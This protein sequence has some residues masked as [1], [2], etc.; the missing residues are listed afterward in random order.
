[1]AFKIESYDFSHTFVRRPLMVHCFACG[2]ICFAS[3]GNFCLKC[4]CELPEAKALLND[5]E[6]RVKFF[7]GKSDK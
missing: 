3:A 1:M 5:C 7:K 4:K 2:E 6:K